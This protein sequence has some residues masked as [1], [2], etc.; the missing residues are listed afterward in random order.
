MPHVESTNT[1][2]PFAKLTKDQQRLL[3]RK[4]PHVPKMAFRGIFSSAVNA[5]AKGVLFGFFTVAFV[6][7]SVFGAYYFI[8]H[9]VAPDIESFLNSPIPESS[10][11]YT[12]DG[13]YLYEIFKDTKRTSISLDEVSPYFKNAMVAAEDRGFYRHPG[14][15]VAS[16]FRASIQNLL[17]PD[18]LVG[19][20]TITQQLVKNVILTPERSVYR[21]IAEA[22]WAQEL[23]KKLSKDQILEKYINYVYFGRNS[24]GIEAASQSYFGK[25]AKELT[26]AESS[27]L[28]ALPKAPSLLSPDGPNQDYLKRRQDYILETMWEEEMISSQELALTRLVTVTPKHQENTLR[29]PFFTLWLKNELL[30]NYG[31]DK[32]YNGGLQVISTLDTKLQDLAE[33][34]VKT[35][36]EKNKKN[37]RA[38][39]AS[40]VA[41]EPA[42]GAVKAMVGSKD[43][44]GQPEPSGCIPGKTC[45]FDP[46]TNV[47]T[48]LRQVGSSFKPYVYLTA[49]GEEFRY[50][51][52]TLVN[53]IS[54][55]FGT[56]GYATYRPSN[57]TGAQYGRVPVRKALAGSL[58]IAAVNTLAEIGME[59][60]IHTLRSLGVTAPME[61]C[62]LAMALGACEMSL[63]EHTSAFSGIANLG[64][65]N[66]ATGVEKITDKTGKLLYQ[67]V[68][69]NRP[70]VNPQSAYMLIDIMSDNDARSYV[71]GKNNPLKFTDRK[72]A[73]KT[74]TTQNWRDGWTVG[75]TPQLTVGVWVGNNDGTYLKYGADSIVSAAPLWRDFM[76]KS[77]ANLPPVDFA[78]P[79]GISRLAINPKTG[80]MLKGKP[81]G[82]KFELFSS[83]AIPYEQ[84]GLALKP[85][86][87]VAGAEKP[88]Y[89]AIL[90]NS[91]ENTVILDPWED[92]LILSTPFDVIVHTG[93]SSEETV[94]DITLD[95][96]PIA[97]LTE[98][99]FVFTVQE[100]LANGTH[101]LSAKATHFGFF[102]STATVKF[103]TFFNPPPLEPR[104]KK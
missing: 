102:E 97:T 49:F 43:Y 53:D 45:R 24:A 71:F 37:Y 96:S 59:P 32:V 44:F 10:K 83:Y 89:E 5:L 42:T 65:Y 103:K 79:E 20:S 1:E 78:E 55:P 26:L 13:S 92:K 35:F 23:E 3:P 12:A 14:V 52:G 100:Q 77:H 76:E 18:E 16:I 31:E 30:K 95:G 48:S 46:N 61:N 50:T 25:P 33:Q 67:N 22:I 56:P 6:A 4:K 39:N 90:E 80:K 104:G 40:L 94:V 85:Q 29:Y 86:G 60:V 73:V 21:K 7:G 17:S 51:P 69:E 70:A 9:A 93:S 11:L 75:F 36:S 41:V 19:G 101:T 34:E 28:A 54:R 2:L 82:A 38:Y 91:G 47:A 72:V 64:K 27:Y 58:N 98:P 62:G 63:L 99:P 8:Y 88:E 81:R 68:P 66:P 84:F 15:S 74:G 57:Y 87:K